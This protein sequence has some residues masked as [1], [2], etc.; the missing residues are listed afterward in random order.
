MSDIP[1]IKNIDFSGFHPLDHSLFDCQGYPGGRKT[2]L[3]YRWEFQW[4]E[5][6]WRETW[7]RVGRHDWVV[8]TRGPA[9]RE[10]HATTAPSQ[11]TMC[12]ACGKRRN[13][14]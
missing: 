9:H 11:F 6:L 7:C 5:R 1:I 4:S 14:E 8:A 13:D 3:K 10:F 12:R 2:H